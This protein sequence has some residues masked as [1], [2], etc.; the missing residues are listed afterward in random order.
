[1]SFINCFT[2][3]SSLNFSNFS[4]TTITDSNGTPINADDTNGRKTLNEYISRVLFS[5]ERMSFNKDSQTGV[6]KGEHFH[7]TPP[8]RNFDVAGPLE[9]IAKI[10]S[11]IPK[12][13]VKQVIRA[14][15]QVWRGHERHQGILQ[16]ALT[17]EKCAYYIKDHSSFFRRRRQ[18]WPILLKKVWNADALKY[19][20]CGGRMKVISFIEQPFDIRHILKHLD[21]W[22][23]PRP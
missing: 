4:Y 12:K 5:L 8:A 21:L 10:A 14:Y 13:G 23:D 16:E 3:H 2:A 7:P 9:W 1:M 20:K 15:S 11:H 6:Y 22:K 19:P 17:E 18:L